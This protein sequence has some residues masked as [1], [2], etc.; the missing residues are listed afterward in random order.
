[1]DAVALKDDLSWPVVAVIACLCLLAVMMWLGLTAQ[2]IASHPY[3]VRFEMDA[4][5]L[6]AVKAI[7]WSAVANG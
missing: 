3:V 1:M 5:T 2:V 4:N 6:E 7:N